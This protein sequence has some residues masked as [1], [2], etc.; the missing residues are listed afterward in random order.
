MEQLGGG[1]YFVP[2]SGANNA[3][4]EFLGHRNRKASSES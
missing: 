1:S 2:L 4:V 3:M